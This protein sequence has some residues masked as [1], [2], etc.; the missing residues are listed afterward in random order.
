[1]IKGNGKRTQWALVVSRCQSENRAGIDATAQVTSDR[2]VR[3]QAK[4]Y[5]LLNGLTKLLFAFL[6]ARVAIRLRPPWGNRNP[7]NGSI[8]CVFH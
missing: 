8:A 6:V 2:N 4:L 5:S 1:M 3:A 7:S